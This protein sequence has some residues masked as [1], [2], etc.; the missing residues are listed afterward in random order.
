MTAVKTMPKAEPTVTP[1]LVIKGAEAAI[2]FYQTVFSAKEIGRLLMPDGTIGHAELQL[3]DSKLMLAEE[4]LAWDNKSP[5][6]LGGTPVTIAVY[7]ANVDATH[8]CALE[9]GAVELMPVKDEFYCGRVGVFLDPFGHKWHI[10]T[11]IEEVS[12]P[13]MQ[14]RLNA[15]FA[16]QPE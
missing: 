6:T 14:K 5:I 3:G 9:A 16:D 15:M 11:L 1:Y 10:M 2:N 7:V 4:S 8:R 12:F 13:E